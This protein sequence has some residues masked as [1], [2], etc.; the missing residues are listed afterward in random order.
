MQDYDVIRL[1]LEGKTEAFE[2]LVERYQRLVYSIAL[3]YMKDP[4]LAEDAAQ[5]AFIKAYTHIRS[6]N[7]E[8]K[9]ST[10]ITRITYNTCIDS[11]RKKR[12]MNPIEEAFEVADNAQT[13][14][15]ALVSKDRRQKLGELINALEPKYKQ[16]LMLYHA[17]GL[18]Y[19]E[20]SEY[21]KVPMSIV[22]NRIFRARKMLKEALESY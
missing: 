7:P 12:E 15:E 19:E 22:K 18:K 2:E 8:F 13:P 14:E 16:P 21:L 20:I 9:F 4:Q 5:E 11:L 17:S 1:C 6:Y 10:W 3:S